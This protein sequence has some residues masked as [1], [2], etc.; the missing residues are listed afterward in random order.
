MAAKQQARLRTSVRHAVENMR[1][2]WGG[3]GGEGGRRVGEVKS[4]SAGGQVCEE[5]SSLD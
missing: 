5:K 4:S 3:G 2:I 1:T